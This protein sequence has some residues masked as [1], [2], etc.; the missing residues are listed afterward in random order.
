MIIKS[1]FFDLK[2][3]GGSDVEGKIKISGKTKTKKQHKIFV[4]IT[5]M[6]WNI[7][8]LSFFIIA[9]V[10]GEYVF[11]KNNIVMFWFFPAKNSKNYFILRLT[12]AHFLREKSH[13]CSCLFTF[14]AATLYVIN[15]I[16]CVCGACSHS[17]AKRFYISV[18]PWNRFIFH[19]FFRGVFVGDI[20][21]NVCMYL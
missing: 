14:I 19:E 6:F 5:I 3:R 7:I 9:S 21:F 15:G 18:F 17:F 8:F 11:L 1:A 4:I 20:I 10:C 2:G 13:H 12:A 16:V